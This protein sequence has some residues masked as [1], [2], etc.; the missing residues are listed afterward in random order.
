MKLF[1][2]CCTPSSQLF[3]ENFA[4]E[5]CGRKVGFI[6]EVAE[7]RPLEPVAGKDDLW[8]VPGSSARYRMCANG[9]DHGVC[10]WMVPADDPA[11][12]CPACAL[13]EVIPD[14]RVEG[15]LE[16]WSRLEQ[17]KRRLMFTLMGLRL[18]IVHPSA[19]GLPERPDLRLRFRFMADSEP[20]TEF[21]V[22]LQEQPRVLTGHAAGEITINVAEADDVARTRAQQ[23]L[24]ERYR[25][26]LGH[27]RH[28]IGHYY[29]DLLVATSKNRLQA[30]REVFGDERQDYAAAV[31]AHYARGRAKASPEHFVSDYASM[32]PW[33]DWAE[34][35]SHY[36][37]MIDTLE[38]ARAY[39][40]HVQRHTLA[41][42]KL[43][44]DNSSTVRAETLFSAW[45]SLSV[46]LNSLNR[47]MGMPDAYPFVM[48]APVRRKMA[49]V[50]GL[51]AESVM[52][53]PRG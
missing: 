38:T 33:E 25:T 6:P 22:P 32:H 21:T 34:T 43:P 49:H 50:H 42:L 39:R 11:C 10:N 18:P 17:A 29:W 35:F 5:H 37:H 24:G 15:N 45:I 3:F 20:S 46:V 27:F 31:S 47:S 51:L 19:K 12:F 40:M 48:S 13:N 36:L 4:C 16:R 1:H 23:Q 9:R 53:P 14:L 41:R 52:P 30:F 44:Q 8:Q 7:M 26:L 2:C 28:E